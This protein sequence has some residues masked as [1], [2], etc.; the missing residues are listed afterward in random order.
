[1]AETL[2][3]LLKICFNGCRHPPKAMVEAEG[4]FLPNATLVCKVSSGLVKL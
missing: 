1:M 4:F 2:C 3:G